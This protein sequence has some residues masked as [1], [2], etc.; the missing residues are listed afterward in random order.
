MRQ[1][2]DPDLVDQAE[3]VLRRVALDPN[4]LK[5]E[6]TEAMIMEEEQHIIGVLRAL[7]APGVR[8]AL[9]DFGS[10]YSRR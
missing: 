2:Q 3:R 1:L 4:R 7:S 9:D 6:I 8:I 10:G 5:L